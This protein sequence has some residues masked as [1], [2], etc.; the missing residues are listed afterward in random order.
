MATII[1]TVKNL[2][3]QAFTVTNQR[4]S[5]PPGVNVDLYAHL[6][7]DRLLESQ[8]ELQGLADRVSIQ[9]VSTDDDSELKASSS[10]TSVGTFVAVNDN[11]TSLRVRGPN[12]STE[13]GIDV[14]SYSGIFYNDAFSGTGTLKTRVIHGANLEMDLEI[15]A[16]HQLRLA[17]V[18][19]TQADGQ[20]WATS[21]TNIVFNTRNDAETASPK[22]LIV[23]RVDTA[24]TGTSNTSDVVLKAS[25]GNLYL[26]LG[27]TDGAVVL[28]PLTTTERDALTPVAG[29]VI[30]NST[31]NKHQ[32]YDGTIWNDLY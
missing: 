6:T 20:I 18:D 10:E 15:Q 29:M 25:S 24:S 1:R 30:F 4:V 9:I 27:V 31:T 13:G 16:P 11:A 21:K 8:D 7:D 5:L 12:H 26:N 2:T 22:Q 19:D 17:S 32:G 28:A 3:S 23:D 14:Q